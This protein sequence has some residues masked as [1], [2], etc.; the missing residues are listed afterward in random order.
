MPVP[1]IGSP[2]SVGSPQA[3]IGADSRIHIAS[4]TAW[5]YRTIVYL[6]AFFPKLAP[7]FFLQGTGTLVAA[8][9]VL[10][11]GHVI[12]D[13]KYG[14]YASRIEVVPAYNRGTAPYGTA[15][16]VRLFTAPGFTG[17]GAATADYGAIKLNTPIGTKTGWLALGSG[18]QVG[19]RL[20]LSG[21][22]GDLNGVLGSMTG[23]VTAVAN[24]LGY[25]TMDSAAGASGSPVYDAAAQIRIIHAFGSATINGGAIIT[26]ARSSQILAWR[27]AWTLLKTSTHLV[28]ALSSS[29]LR[30]SN[31]AFA[32]QGKNT[33]NTV[34]QVRQ[35]YLGWNGGRYYTV[36]NA[37]GQYLGYSNVTNFR[38]VATTAVNRY[39]VVRS[40]TATRYKNLYLNASAGTT[41]AYYTRSV[42]VTSK[43]VNG[44]NNRAY[45]SVYTKKGGTW[46]GYISTAAIR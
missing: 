42:Y 4:T 18:A 19:Q 44:V 12:Y 6:R 46:L 39:L 28:Y 15:T 27:N 35:T 2:T 14:G 17:T 24:T 5:P 7:G 41:A 22:S 10:T 13:T 43:N 20:T 1:L 16:S 21:Y 45:Y 8:D 37:Q 30:Y 33:L 31:T 9:T 25:Y 23:P 40:K 36:Y 3:I 11:A 26:A 29:S 32:V 38:T 34:Y